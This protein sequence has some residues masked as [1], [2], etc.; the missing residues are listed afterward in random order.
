M[1]SSKTSRSKI[2]RSGIFRENDGGEVPAYRRAFAL[3]SSL[4]LVF[5][6]SLVALEFSRGTSI[7]LRLAVNHSLA[8]KAYYYAFAGYQTALRLLTLDEN[9]FDGPG[10]AWYGILPPIPLEDGSLNVT[11][12]DEK[13][14]Y[15]MRRLVTDFGAADERRRVMLERIFETLELEPGLGDALIDWQDSD[16][17]ALP[18]GAEAYFYNTR[19]P[20]YAP[21]NG[22]LTTIGEILLIR[23]IDRDVLF[24]SPAGRAPYADPS[25]GPLS[26]YVTVYGDGRINV[27]TAEFPVLLCLSRD[28]DANIVEDIIERREEDAFESL[29]EL[30]EVESV[31]DVLYNEISSLISIESDI[32]RIVATGITGDFSRRIEAVVKREGNRIRVVYFNGAL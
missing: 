10:D 7:N 11:I 12:T 1:F 14:R 27:N 13:A 24:Q 3:V 19:E 21:P 9:D 28:M 15:N 18:M 25:L 30:K 16:E 6:L 4:V 26:R 2:F 31:S 8:K 5:I 32:F 29:A 22:R 20:P 17:T 23:N